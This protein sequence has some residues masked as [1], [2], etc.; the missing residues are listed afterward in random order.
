MAQ[1]LVPM[2][3]VSI[4]GP[5][6]R[7]RKA[8]DCFKG[9]PVRCAICLGEERMA[10]GYLTGYTYELLRRFIDYTGSPSKIIIAD[11]PLACLDSLLQDSLDIVA[12]PYRKDV[13]ASGSLIP[14]LLIGEGGEEAM[15]GLRVSTP[16]DS[17]LLWA[18]KADKDTQ[19]T[20][21]QWI[22]AFNSS[23]SRDSLRTRFF[24]GYNPFRRTGKVAGLISPYDAL[25]KE[26]A[27][28]HGLDW[29]LLAALSW[30]ESRFR[31]QTRSPRGA[32]G[33][34]QIVPRTANRFG[35]E[36]HLD[37]EQ[38]IKA[39]AELLAHLKESFKDIAADEEDQD[40]F[41]LAAYNAGK[42]RIL[43]CIRYASSIGID[44]SRW[45]SLSTVFPKMST[46]SVELVDEV[47]LG[48]FKGTETTAYVDAV[49]RVYSRFKGICPKAGDPPLGNRSTEET[50]SDSLLRPDSLGGIDPGDEQGRHQHEQQ[51]GEVG[52]DVRGED[53][54]EVELHRHE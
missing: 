48:R 9:Q 20:I 29:R 27:A 36:S 11:D 19:K 24:D 42:A 18:F 39:G 30:S 49:M 28:D 17:C 4:I 32:R 50:G 5:C 10:D 37:P 7:E 38:N 21:N 43:D 52:A 15:E 26:Q 2:L 53:R 22:G 31:I 51:D 41:A 35:V 8:E 46:D 47:K 33:L 14:A 44:T 40:K 13:A 6:F 45:D 54:G 1:V 16:I 3:V 23:P 34:M 25:F 12:L